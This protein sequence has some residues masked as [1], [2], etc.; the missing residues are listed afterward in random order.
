MKKVIFD[1]DIGIDDAMALLFLHFAPEVELV[2]LTTVFGNASLEDVTRNMLH[3]KDKFSIDAPVYVGADKPLGQPLGKL[4]GDDY[5]DFV[6]GKNGLGDIPIGK[7]VSKVE[8]TPAAQAII[9]IVRANPGEISMLAVG[10]LSNLAT[11]LQ[12]D[13]EIAGLLKELIC[14]GGMFGYNGHKGNVSPVA[15][16][17]IG[18]DP[19]AADVVACSGIN[20]TF[21]GLDVT[22]DTVF[23]Q[24][25]IERLRQDAGEAGEFIHQI[26]RV[27][28]DFYKSLRG[29]AMCPMHDSSAVAYLLNPS[30][31]QT[32]SAVVRV[33]REGVA[34]GQTIAGSLTGDNT[35]YVNDSWYQSNGSKLKECSFC[36]AVDGEGVL[37][38]YR[39]TLSQE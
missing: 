27:Y 12:Q 7:P 36:V 17:N 24:T 21:V 28:F 29:E 35:S 20:A 31:Y 33:A 9:D 25:F 1:S 13:P 10:R 23:D 6:H 15:E 32:K 37:D 2:A 14:M 22:E 3:V 5:P 39:Q 4:E 8:K 16:A 26:T 34:I 30:L 38:L 18:G 11:A 19:A